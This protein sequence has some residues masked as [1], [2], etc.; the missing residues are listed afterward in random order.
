MM[1]WQQS[2]SRSLIVLVD[3]LFVLFIVEIGSGWAQT[4]EKENP[5]EGNENEE[6][7]TRTL[8]AISLGKI[9][10]P[11]RA[12]IPVLTKLL[13]DGTNDD[14]LRAMCAVALGSVDP[15]SESVLQSVLGDSSKAVQ[16]AAA[17]AVCQLHGRG[18]EAGLHHLVRLL[19]D[20]DAGELASRALIDIGAVAVP[21]LSAVV[22]DSQN[23]SH[24]PFSVPN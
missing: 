24:A 22:L 11:A 1:E 17:Y 3:V 20:E 6:D 19:T 4:G 5:D 23:A 2:V 8:A 16:V 7:E 9:G 15:A 13:Q 14:E 21:L 18:S 12:A 10:K